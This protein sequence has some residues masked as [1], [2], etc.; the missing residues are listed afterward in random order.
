MPKFGVRV[1][2]NLTKDEARSRL[3]R[4]IEMLEAK[5]ANQV[6]DLQQSWDGDTLKFHFKTYG[7]PLDG[8]I[9]VADNELNLAGE[10]PFAAMMFKGKIES[11][12]REQLEKLVAA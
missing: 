12:I 10:M 11:E 6:G 3:E 4:F 8:G 5:F 2:H 9:T 7:I 1:P